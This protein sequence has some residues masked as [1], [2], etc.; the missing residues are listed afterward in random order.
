MAVSRKEMLETLTELFGFRQFRPSQEEIVR[1]ILD[2]RD[3]FAVM[4]TGG[5]KSLCYQLPARL[6]GGLCVVI[7]PLIALMK[8]QVDAANANGLRAASL[9]S[10][11]SA[12]EKKRVYTALRYHELDLLYISPE[13]FNT[14]GFTD[15][16][17]SL[18]VT[19]FAVDEAHCI[20]EWGHDFR[21]DY[22][23]L[24][25]MVDEFP[26]VPVAAFTA[27]AT[28]GVSD[29]IVTKLKLRDPYLVRVSFN[30]P[31]LYY[32]VEPKQQVEEQILEYVRKHPEAPGIIYRTSRKKVE[33]TAEL[34]REQGVT[35]KA[36]HAGMSDAD[37]QT[38]QEAF[39]Q[40]ECLVI[41]ATIA[42]GMGIDKP[43]VRYVIHGDLPKN[44]EGYYQETGRAGR[45]GDPAECILF[46]GKQDPIILEHFIDEMIDP[47]AQNIARLQLRQMRSYAR[48]DR[49]R[50]ASLL[51]Y[52]GETWAPSESE[53]PTRCCDICDG[54]I[55]R[56]DATIPAQKI[57]SAIWR[58]GERFGGTH[59]IDIVVGNLSERVKRFGHEKLPTFGVGA[60]RSKAFWR[61][62]IDALVAQDFLQEIPIP[63]LPKFCTLKMSPQAWTIL[64]G[65]VSFQMPHREEKRRTRKRRDLATQMGAATANAQRP[66]G[67]ATFTHKKMW[68]GDKKTLVPSGETLG[69]T[70]VL[71]EEY[72]ERKSPAE[73]RCEGDRCDQK[74]K[75][76]S[77]QETPYSAELFAKLRELRRNIAKEKKIPPYCV[78]PDKTLR[79]MCTVYPRTMDEFIQIYG[80]SRRKYE[81]YGETFMTIIQQYCGEMG[82]E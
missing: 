3:V 18:N 12:P 35:V 10:A 65:Q 34:L 73:T 51:Q 62:V 68:E 20:S 74:G 40:D 78:F 60:D 5:G 14:E 49:C 80:V 79:E 11:S 44:I 24:S 57:L 33:E 46:F 21:T 55:V 2:G 75:Q 72:R 77:D 7:S 47:M 1:A 45:D 15:Y 81:S 69:E 39:R 23:S 67:A 56:E 42:F 70:L 22:L 41:V 16:L 28:P 25:R 59:I 76:N 6:L 38:T 17:K 13:R 4:P 50:R 63:D 58:T 36:Y 27:T 61:V 37:R 43:N 32:R 19:Y 48:S 71:D 66:T 8:D 9:N 53:A 30:R 31:N 64:R 54:N 52:F 26:N 29:D 82:M